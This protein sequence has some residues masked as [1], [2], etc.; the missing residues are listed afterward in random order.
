MQLGNG[1][2]YR[3]GF[4]QLVPFLFIWSDHVFLDQSLSPVCTWH[5][6]ILSSIIL[7]NYSVHC[8]PNYHIFLNIPHTFLK[9]ADQKLGCSA[10]SHPDIGGMVVFHYMMMCLLSAYPSEASKPQ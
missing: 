5:F 9:N 3:L 2:L 4:V 1:T 6:G 8:F 10:Y 7:S